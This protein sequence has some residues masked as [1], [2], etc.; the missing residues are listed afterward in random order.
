[1]G[2]IQCERIDF[3]AIALAPTAFARPRVAGCATEVL[4]GSHVC[5]LHYNAII[6]RSVP[7]PRRRRRWRRGRKPN[8]C[9]CSCSSVVS[10]RGR[11]RKSCGV[12]RSRGRR[13]AVGPKIVGLVYG[14]RTK[15]DE[16]VSSVRVF[17]VS[18]I[19]SSGSGSD[20]RRRQCFLLWKDIFARGERGFSV[21]DGDISFLGLSAGPLPGSLLVLDGFGLGKDHESHKGNGD[22]DH[23]LE[24]HRNLEQQP[25]ADDGENSP[26]AVEGRV[27]DD[28][29]S[30][31]QIGRCQVVGRKGEPVSDRPQCVLFDDSEKV[32]CREISRRASG[33]A[34]QVRAVPDQGGNHQ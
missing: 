3:T 12:S 8:R 7:H 5:T 22:P 6:V 19:D 16:A 28:A 1:M 10:R 25:G 18:A 30:R 23:A 17:L 4:A 15:L 11:Y 34:E 20:R 29:D 26:G 21:S 27:V 24:G 2:R 13:S 33:V 31:Q 32:L 9:C 14:R